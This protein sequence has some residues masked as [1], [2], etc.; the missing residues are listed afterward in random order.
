M[1]QLKVKV[2]VDSEIIGLTDDVSVDKLPLDR[3]HAVLVSTV[4]V[5]NGNIVIANVPLLLVVLG[6]R[7]V[8]GH[9][10]GGVV[11]H[12]H[13]VILPHNVE[14]TVIPGVQTSQEHLG[15]V[16]GRDVNQG[17]QAREEGGVSVGAILVTRSKINVSSIES[18]DN[19]LY[20]NIASSS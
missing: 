17:A 12:L 11:D 2:T 9:E 15:L 20:L 13:G 16:S 8:G 10:G 5:N 6:V 3:A 1:V 18:R 14:L 7:V 4:I 19:V